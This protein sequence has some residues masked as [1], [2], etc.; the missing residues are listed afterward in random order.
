MILPAREGISYIPRVG[1]N[2]YKNKLLPPSGWRHLK[3]LA[4]I[5][6]RWTFSV[7][8]ALWWELTGDPKIFHT[9]P[10][11]AQTPHLLTSTYLPTLLFQV[12]DHS[13]N[14]F[15]TAQSPCFHHISG[16]LC[17]HTKLSNQCTAH[18]PPTKR[19]FLLTVLQSVAGWGYSTPFSVSVNISCLPIYVQCLCFS[20]CVSCSQETPMKG[21]LGGSDG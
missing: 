16:D 17:V 14:S 4:L 13:A 5:H 3:E 1:V 19:I 7:L 6:T 8:D 12:S 15:T 11:G 10:I 2:F 20:S 9:V 21:H 18:R